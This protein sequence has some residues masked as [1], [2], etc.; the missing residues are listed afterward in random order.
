MSVI[1]S[2][3][4]ALP[5]TPGGNQMA[6][7]FGFVDTP[8]FLHYRSFDEVDWLSVFGAEAATIVLAPVTISEINEKKDEGTS[9]V[10][11]RAA[12]VLRKLEALW[13][14]KASIRPGIN[15]LVQDVEPTIDYGSNELDYRCK[16]DRLLAAILQ[17]KASNPE[18]EA[19]L[20]TADLG[21]RLKARRHEI[22]A[23]ALEDNLKLPDDL[24]ANEK[25]IQQLE[26]QLIEIKH[27]MPNLE[28]T[29]PGGS[30]NLQVNLEPPIETFRRGHSKREKANSAKT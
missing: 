8:I 3:T 12:S 24:D 28:L 4:A 26:R 7:K 17:F 20:V 18:K 27:M 1:I 13:D 15:L 16:D 5:S 23:L 10:R 25:R 30:N 19:L 14:K 6:E 22:T 2:L 29:F 11:H 9:K 21:L